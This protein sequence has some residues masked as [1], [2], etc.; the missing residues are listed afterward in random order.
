MAEGR[1]DH[2][3]V[4]APNNLKGIIEVM[5]LQGHHTT[6]M[7][8]TTP[9]KQEISRQIRPEIEMAGPSQ[10]GQYDCA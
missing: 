8:V 6:D 5:P 2:L 1:R 3:T 7:Q 9:L 4:T 10:T